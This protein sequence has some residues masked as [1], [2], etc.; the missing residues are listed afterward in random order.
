[1]KRLLIALVIVVMVP[2]AAC[3]TR[4]E[5]VTPVPVTV[6]ATTIVT[7][8]TRAPVITTTLT[9][10]GPPSTEK[11]SSVRITSVHVDGSRV[12][13]S[14]ETNL[15]DGTVFHSQLAKGSA[16]LRWWPSAKDIIAAGGKWAIT[17]P[18]GE[19]G[20]PAT[21]EK[22]PGYYF[23]I[24]ARDNRAVSGVMIFDLGALPVPTS[25]ATGP[26][27][28]VVSVSQ[29]RE[30]GGI[31]NPGGPNI[32]VTLKNISSEPIVSL[33]AFLTLSGG[34]SHGAFT[35]D[36]GLSPE[37]PLMPGAIASRSKILIGGAYDPSVPQ[38]LG[39][40]G[41]TRSGRAFTQENWV[42]IK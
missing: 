31:V 25:T 23:E 21:L 13:L 8:A 40:T 12:I 2:P 33:S 11:I 19:N 38:P 35:Y 32:E 10:T 18:L 42:L 22:G 17:V 15:P 9:I 5:T 4:T 7:V 41:K 16:L 3:G 1:M 37:N 28:Q 36:F 24:W 20:A 6:T 27:I 26:D 34:L 29:V 30:P 14:G 39:I